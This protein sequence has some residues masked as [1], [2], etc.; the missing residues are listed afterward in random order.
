MSIPDVRMIFALLNLNIKLLTIQATHLYGFAYAN[1]IAYRQ[2]DL[3]SIFH[4]LAVNTGF[5][6]LQFFSC[7]SHDPC[8]ISYVTRVIILLCNLLHPIPIH[9]KFTIKIESVY[10][11]ENVCTELTYVTQTFSAE[12]VLCLTKMMCVYEFFFCFLVVIYEYSTKISLIN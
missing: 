3:I 2:L 9:F 10:V 1:Q 7:S 12:S 11:M 5:F 4:V 8:M 6:V